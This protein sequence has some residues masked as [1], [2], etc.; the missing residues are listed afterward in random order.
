MCANRA[1]R[2]VRLNYT[3]AESAIHKQTNV[4]TCNTAQVPPNPDARFL[5]LSEVAE[6]LNISMSQTYALV[7]NKEIRSVKI[8]GRGQ[9]R[10]GRNDLEEYIQRCYA[11]TEKFLDDHPFSRDEV[12]PSD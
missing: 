12:V 10:V 3:S 5:S 6:I 7:R 8:G 4:N 1:T 2:T 11:E 9:Y